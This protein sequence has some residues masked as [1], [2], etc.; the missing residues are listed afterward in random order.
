MAHHPRARRAGGF[1]MFLLLLVVVVVGV[2]FWQGW[3]ALSTNTDGEGDGQTN[4]TLT[5]DK[6]KMEQ[7]TSSAIEATRREAREAGEKI[8][9]A[10]DLESVQGVVQS[11]D[12]AQNTI[13]LRTDEGD[14]QTFRAGDGTEIAVDD[15]ETTLSGIS[16]GDQAVIVYKDGDGDERIVNSITITKDDSAGEQ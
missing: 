9:A 2:G 16:A 6:E 12:A 10:A 5:I 8:S 14:V 4:V 13:T 1:L 15:E 3:F 7:D 11:V